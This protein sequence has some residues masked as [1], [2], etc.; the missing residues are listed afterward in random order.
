M[1]ILTN[2]TFTLYVCR[3]LMD[4]FLIADKRARHPSSY[5]DGEERYQKKLCLVQVALNLI[6]GFE[7]AVL[8]RQQAGKK[9]E[10]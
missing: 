3:Y 1:A 5:R 10:L 4:L 9:A 2:L 6:H 7:T 8:I